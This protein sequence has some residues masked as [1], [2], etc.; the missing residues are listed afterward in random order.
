MG[1]DFDVE[2]DEGDD[3]VEFDLKNIVY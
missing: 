2:V 1:F 3:D